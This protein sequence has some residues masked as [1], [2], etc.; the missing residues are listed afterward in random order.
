MNR[1]GNCRTGSRQGWKRLAGPPGS[2]RDNAMSDTRCR[3]RSQT[4]LELLEGLA[5]F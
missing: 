4:A 3:P 5:D 1:D 2:Q